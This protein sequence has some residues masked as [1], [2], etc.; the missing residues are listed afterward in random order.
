MAHRQQRKWTKLEVPCEEG[1]RKTKIKALHEESPQPPTQWA[2]CGT[3]Q[4]PLAR[5]QSLGDSLC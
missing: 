4:S 5:G 3:E 2:L 1:G